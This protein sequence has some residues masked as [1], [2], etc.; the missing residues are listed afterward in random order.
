MNGQVTIKFNQQMNTSINTSWINQSNTQILVL[1]QDK[2][3]QE[4]GFNYSKLN[5]DWVVDSYHKDAM[6]INLTFSNPLEIS[7]NIV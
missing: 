5:L 4:L 1:P 6:K 2:R 3:D 7:P